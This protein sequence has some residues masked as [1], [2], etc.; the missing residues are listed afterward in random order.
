MAML[1]VFALAKEAVAATQDD[2]E[3]SVLT[4]KEILRLLDV[5]G[6]RNPHLENPLN[7]PRLGYIR[8][9]QTPLR[10]DEP[11]YGEFL[12]LKH[13]A[14]DPFVQLVD[15]D[16]LESLAQFLAS[17]SGL[18]NFFITYCIAFINGKVARYR[19][20]YS[21]EDGSVALFDKH[22]QNTKGPQAAEGAG[23]RWVVWDDGP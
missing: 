22:L 2:P 3:G 5:E 16:N 1:T 15:H 13:C 7:H 11:V 23:K 12:S 20:A 18:V 17:G 6:T 19:V 8:A 9:R 4:V 14:H 21:A 10:G